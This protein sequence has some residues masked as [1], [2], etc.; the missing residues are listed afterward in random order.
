[1]CNPRPISARAGAGVLSCQGRIGRI[2][3]NYF[4]V[5]GK[6]F[7]CGLGETPGEAPVLLGFAGASR[8]REYCIWETFTCPRAAQDVECESV[9]GTHRVGRAARFAMPFRD[10]SAIPRQ[11]GSLLS[12]LPT[13]GF[14]RAEIP[15]LGD[16]ARPLEKRHQ[17]PHG[18]YF[19]AASE[20]RRKY[21]DAP[22][23]RAIWSMRWRLVA[24]WS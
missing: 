23:G 20:A 18:P 5:F 1:M 19:C 15:R 13:I 3:A 6:S 17:T 7:G 8:R 14:C 16:L 10:N 22:D 2:M 11:T 4:E 24:A 9:R 21:H 12:Q